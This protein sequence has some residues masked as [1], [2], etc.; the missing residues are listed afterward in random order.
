M[1]RQN[2]HIYPPKSII[3]NLILESMS[4]IKSAN[5]FLVNKALNLVIK[6]QT[7]TVKNLFMDEFNSYQYFNIEKDG[8]K[9]K[10]R[11]FSI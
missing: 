8:N 6:I 5:N 1:G 10:N 2:E 4:E 3:S 9:V 11:H 7:Q